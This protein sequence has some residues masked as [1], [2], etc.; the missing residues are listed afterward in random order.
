MAYEIF[1]VIGSQKKFNIFFVMFHGPLFNGDGFAVKTILSMEHKPIG[2][3]FGL[4]TKPR[5]FLDVSTYGT[6]QKS[7]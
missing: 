4:L 2:E 6:I 5:L 7:P 1:T 3:K